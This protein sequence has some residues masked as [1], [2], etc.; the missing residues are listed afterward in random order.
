MLIRQFPNQKHTLKKEPN[1]YS[2]CKLLYYP[3]DSVEQKIQQQSER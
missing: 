3:T 1:T 2:I